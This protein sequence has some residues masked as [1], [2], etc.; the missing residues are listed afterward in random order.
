MDFPLLCELIDKRQPSEQQQQREPTEKRLFVEFCL[1][2]S[3][4][5]CCANEQQSGMCLRTMLTEHSIHIQTSTPARPEASFV[6]L[7]NIGEEIE[8][9][10][11]R[12]LFDGVEVEAKNWWE[13]SSSSCCVLF[14]SGI[15]RFTRHNS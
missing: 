13:E 12:E 10:R 9:S 8:Q 14:S 11:E 4:F 6:L 3:I 1:K 2:N 7:C 15:R 5:L